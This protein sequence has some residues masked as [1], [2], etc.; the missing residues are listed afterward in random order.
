MLQRTII[1]AFLKESLVIESFGTLNT[2]LI[3]ELK[4]VLSTFKGEVSVE[5]MKKALKNVMVIDATIDTAIG[6]AI[7]GLTVGP[8]QTSSKGYYGG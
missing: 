5:K 3:S 4:S 7:D 6:S 8:V 1:T 2:T